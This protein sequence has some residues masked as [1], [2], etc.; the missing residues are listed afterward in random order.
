LFVTG[1]THDVDAHAFEELGRPVF[2]AQLRP[3]Q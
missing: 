2:D 3:F 1:E